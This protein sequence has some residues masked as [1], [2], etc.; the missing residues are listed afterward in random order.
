[1]TLIFK[2]VRGPEGGV[3]VL[4]RGGGG[5]NGGVEGR[6]GMENGEMEPHSK[7]TVKVKWPH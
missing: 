6:G 2:V 7:Q 1:M 3:G 5:D 4:G